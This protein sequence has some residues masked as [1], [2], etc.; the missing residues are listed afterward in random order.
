M[1]QKCEDPPQRML[2][3]TSMPGSDRKELSEFCENGTKWQAAL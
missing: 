2:K 3:D 1:S